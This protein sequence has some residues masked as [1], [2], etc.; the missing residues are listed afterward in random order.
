MSEQG[1]Q[2][3]G[4]GSKQAPIIVELLTRSKV[5]PQHLQQSKHVRDVANRNIRESGV[6]LKMLSVIS[7]TARD[8][9]AA[10]ASLRQLPLLILMSST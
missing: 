3:R 7:V 5:V 2:L 9:I 4:D 10:N 1:Q 8:T 6:Q